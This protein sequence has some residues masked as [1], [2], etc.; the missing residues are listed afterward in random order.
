MK[1]RNHRENLKGYCCAQCEKFYKLA[2]LDLSEISRHRY[3]ETPPTTPPGF[4]D[5]TFADE[6]PRRPPAK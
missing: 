1:R 2:E 5:L 6:E 4:W 3:E